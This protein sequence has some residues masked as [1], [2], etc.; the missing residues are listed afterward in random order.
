MRSSTRASCSATSGYVKQRLS[1]KH[2][3]L[4]KQSLL[5][6][7]AANNLNTSSRN[8]MLS[9]VLQTDTAEALF[10]AV[11][12]AVY[13]EAARQLG[14]T[15]EHNGQFRSRP[16]LTM[17]G[18]SAGHVHNLTEP[19]A[20]SNVLSIR[21][22]WA[23]FDLYA[24]LT[25]PRADPQEPPLEQPVSYAALPQESDTGYEEMRSKSNAKLRQVLVATA[26]GNI[27]ERV[28]QISR[29]KN[30][31]GASITT[32]GAIHRGLNIRQRVALCLIYSHVS[33]QALALRSRSGWRTGS[34]TSSSG[35]SGGGS[36]RQRRRSSSRKPTGGTCSR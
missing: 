27:E 20:P 9:Y 16:E 7:S 1:R 14:T 24:V 28:R 33:V 17:K 23:G 21:C 25:I 36:T 30:K 34:V 12:V 22:D 5:A 29:S 18:W 31:I 3:L 13:R 6:A 4:L 19:R 11:D 26:G 32:F 15:L 8:Y 10:T 35:R 2:L